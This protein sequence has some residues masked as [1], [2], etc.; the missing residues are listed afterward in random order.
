MKSHHYSTKGQYRA[1]RCLEY[2]CPGDSECSCDTGK[3]AVKLGDAQPSTVTVIGSTSWPGIESTSTPFVQTS[4]LVA[5]GTATSES[6]GLTSSTTSISTSSITPTSSPTTNGVAAAAAAS[7]T[8]NTP[9]PSTGG[10]SSNTGLAAGLGAGL[11]AAAV[12]I[13]VL[14]FFLI[15]NRRHRNAEKEG[16]G[17]AGY[18]GLLQGDQTMQ[19]PLSVASQPASAYSDNQQQHVVAEAPPSRDDRPELA[20]AGEYERVEMPSGQNGD[21]LHHQRSTE[22]AELGP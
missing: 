20:G 3:N 22:R 7:A 2:C 5:N 4:P 21:R 17:D 13:G 1:N 15:R 11:G 10:S 12:I 19:K 18:S 6:G 9:A 8:S 16:P 14:I